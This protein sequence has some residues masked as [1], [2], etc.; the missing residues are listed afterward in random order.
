MQEDQIGGRGLKKVW[1]NDE[2][3]VNSNGMSG[4]SSGEIYGLI[5]GVL[6]EH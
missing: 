4:V 5:L 2:I 1:K 3:H 6:R